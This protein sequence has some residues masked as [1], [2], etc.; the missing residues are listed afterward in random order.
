MEKIVYI[1]SI[2]H[3]PII[4]L[5]AKDIVEDIKGTRED[6]KEE[7]GNMWETMLTMPPLMRMTAL[8]LIFIDVTI[9]FLYI[10]SAIII[11]YQGGSLIFPVVGAMLSI[12]LIVSTANIIKRMFKGEG[13]TF[14]KD[15]ISKIA[16]VCRI[17]YGVYIMFYFAGSIVN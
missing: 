5:T 13:I 3:L 4:A 14:E 2:L 6:N 8:I 12:Y 1:L 7:I 17:V 11:Y 9:I 15:I 16:Q 10:N